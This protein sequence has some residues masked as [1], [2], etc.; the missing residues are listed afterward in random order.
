MGGICRGRRGAINRGTVRECLLSGGSV[1]A[2]FEGRFQLEEDGLL[3]EY[4][5]ALVAESLD[6]AFQEV[7]LLGH[8]GVSH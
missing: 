5:L 6:L 8:L 4:F 3:H 7:D 2:Y 1:T